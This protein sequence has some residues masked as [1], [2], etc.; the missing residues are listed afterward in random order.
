MFRGGG[1][2]D[3]YG[4]GITAPLVPGYMGGGQIGGGIIYG[5]PMADGRFGFQAPVMFNAAEMTMPASGSVVSGLE[6]LAKNK[7]LRDGNVPMIPVNV[8]GVVDQK[9]SETEVNQEGDTKLIADQKD[10]IQKFTENDQ[11]G[12][13][14]T[15]DG[16]DYLDFTNEELGVNENTILPGE[17]IIE[18]DGVKVQ[19][20]NTKLVPVN[21]DDSFGPVKRV[22]DT[23][24]VPS[25]VEGANKNMKSFPRD[26][27][28]MGAASTLTIAEGED[29]DGEFEEKVELSAKDAIA[30]NQKLFAELLGADKARGQDIGDMLL[31][32]SGSGGNTLGEKFQN[33]VKAESAAG[34]SRSEKIKQTAAG[35]AIN[36][37]VA[38]KRSKEQIE[39]L[40]TKIDYTQDRKDASVQLSVDDPLPLAKAKSAKLADSSV[41]SDATIANLIQTKVFSQTGSTPNVHRPPIKLKNI[42]KSKSQEKLKVGYNLV[43]NDGITTIVS[44][45]GNNY[46]ILGT[47]DT[48]WSS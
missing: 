29:G 6:L 7:A 27:E 10:F 46:S 18:I 23:S 12:K 43:D 39:A 9:Q 3:S 30:E 36:D 17:E 34:P 37:Y 33:Y 16:L 1:T 38:G 19:K 24:K 45:D 13:T 40:K 11:I 35:L 4:T 20:K 22:I 44:W 26:A 28:D 42:D 41:N 15:S 48:F 2:V 31:R 21:E 25:D 47:I 5:K 32:F 14:E 8:P